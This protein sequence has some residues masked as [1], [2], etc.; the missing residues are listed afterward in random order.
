MFKWLGRCCCKTS[1]PPCPGFPN[2][3]GWYATPIPNCPQCGDCP[4]CPTSPLFVGYDTDVIAGC[5]KCVDCPPCEGLSGF[6]GYPHGG[7][8]AAGCSECP[9]PDIDC[10]CSSSQA[11]ANCC[12]ICSPLANPGLSDHGKAGRF[13]TVQISGV[14]LPAQ[15]PTESPC[16]PG[17][18]YKFTGTP[19]GS[20][21]IS[22][23]TDCT[24]STGTV[25]GMNY[26][27]V[28]GPASCNVVLSENH[29]IAM[30]LTFIRLGTVLTA[31]FSY[32]HNFG[33]LM[34]TA[35]QTITNCCQPFT[36]TNENAQCSGGHA[37]G[38]NGTATFT[39]V[40]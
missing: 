28:D 27:T 13:Y 16:V 15:C 21:M 38:I 19:N 35:T 7:P 4:P 9:P 3:H 11:V 10:K 2:K 12:F 25:D 20:W 33:V 23:S 29:T 37:N 6:Y 26:A 24:W 34:F 1:C 18:Y 8:A 14:T 31:T 5:P 22:P 40:V 36:L 32:V 17:S 30:Q 39:P